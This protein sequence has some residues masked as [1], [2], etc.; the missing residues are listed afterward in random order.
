[1]MSHN[2][3]HGFNCGYRL[4][5]IASHLAAMADLTQHYQ[6]EMLSRE[7][8]VRYEDLVS[9]PESTIRLLLEQAGVP[10]E[11]ACLRFYEQ[12]GYAATPSY[13]QVS[14][15]LNGQSIGR[16]RHYATHLREFEPL[17]L[18]VMSAMSYRGP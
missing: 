11:A 13:A 4:A 5:D 9:N 2:F 15:K 1:M 7:L 12:S 14:E 8:V 10:F 3:T 18:P 17:L 6:R 16:H